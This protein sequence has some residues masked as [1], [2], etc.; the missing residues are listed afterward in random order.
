[1]KMNRSYF[2]FMKINFSL[3]SPDG[4]ENRKLKFGYLLRFAKNSLLVRINYSNVVK[5]KIIKI[6]HRKYFT[7]LL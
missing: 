6:K 2:Q 4:D 1:M 5:T 3:L 7:Y